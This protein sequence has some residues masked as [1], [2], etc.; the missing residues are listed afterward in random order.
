MTGQYSVRIAV[1]H[2]PVDLV[3][4]WLPDELELAPQG[5][6]PAGY[7]PCNLLHG[8]ESNVYFNINPFFK[9]NY[10]EFGL[11]VPFIRWKQQRYK[12]NGPFLFTPIIFVDS[13]IVSF[14]GEVVFGFPKRMADFSV[15]DTKY[16]CTD[17]QVH[18]P[19]VQASYR[20]LGTSPRPEALSLITDCL[21]QPSVSQ[22]QNRTFTESGFFWD[23]GNATFEDIAIDGAITEYLFPGVA[24][25]RRDY[26]AAG[27]KDFRAGAAY[28]MQTR[29]TLT[30]PTTNLNRDWTAWNAA[31]ELET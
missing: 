3:R 7:H 14:G 31:T 23:I 20:A 27:T 29:W 25:G 1:Q 12:Y 16:D 26:S 17:S 8:I 24:C 21:Q 4:T 5:V 18:T 2:L 28:H 30:M 19:Y 10:F 22:K 15:S 11:V 6:S 9:L 13:Q